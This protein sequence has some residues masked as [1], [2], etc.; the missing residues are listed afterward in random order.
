M[1]PFSQRKGRYTPP[2]TLV[3]TTWPRSLIASALLSVL[4]GS[5]P[6]SVRLPACQRNAVLPLVPTIWPRSLIAIGPPQK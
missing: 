6:R 4:P 1:R 5:V 2:R 3:P